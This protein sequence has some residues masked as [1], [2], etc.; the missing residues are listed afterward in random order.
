[1][2]GME[3]EEIA[4]ISRESESQKRGFRKGKEKAEPV[5]EERLRER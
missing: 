4:L 1:M 5:K 2:R 3:E